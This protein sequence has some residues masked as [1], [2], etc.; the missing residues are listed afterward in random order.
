MKYDIKREELIFEPITVSI[1][2][3]T[4]EDL[5]TFL[6]LLHIPNKVLNEYNTYNVPNDSGRMYDLWD[7]LD[8]IAIKL[9]LK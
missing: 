9:G 7:E 4:P 1:V 5:C 2:L 6:T 3:E 8:D